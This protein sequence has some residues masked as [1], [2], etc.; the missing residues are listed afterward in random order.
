MSG[1]G[2]TASLL[3]G[4]GRRYRLSIRPAFPH[5][6]QMGAKHVRQSARLF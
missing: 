1:Q 2:M 3:H 4:K 6:E 5:F